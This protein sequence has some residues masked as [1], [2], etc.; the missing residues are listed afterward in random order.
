M[1]CRF[2][3]CDIDQKPILDFPDEIL[4]HIF[5]FCHILERIRFRLVCR[6]WCRLSLYGIHQLFLGQNSNGILEIDFKNRIYFP[7]QQHARIL[8][9]ATF[10]LKEIGS[11]LH[12]LYTNPICLVVRPTTYSSL[13]LPIYDYFCKFVQI[14]IDYCPNL[15]ELDL[16]SEHPF[17]QMHKVVIQPLTNLA[18]HFGHQLKVFRVTLCL[19]DD[20]Q[21]FLNYLNPQKLRRFSFFLKTPSWL[22]DVCHRFPLLTELEVVS[23]F[24]FRTLPWNSLKKLINIR[25]IRIQTVFFDQFWFTVPNGQDSIDQIV[26]FLEF[27]YPYTRIPNDLKDRSLIKK[28]RILDAETLGYQCQELPYLENVIMTSLTFREL[29]HLKHLKCL[30][31]L[32]F[33]ESEV[34]LESMFPIPSLSRLNFRRIF[35]G[36]DTEKNIRQEKLLTELGRIFPNVED[37]KITTSGSNTSAL[38]EYVKTLPNLRLFI[39]ALDPDELVKVKEEKQLISVCNSR[40]VYLVLTKIRPLRMD[41]D[42]LS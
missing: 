28:M 34:R 25:K 7:I 13:D 16:G 26:K 18:K 37:V 38:I 40:N 36:T 2:C 11:S 23:L 14:L 19:A 17:L 4:L 1:T 12:S 27:Y 6:K 29:Y 33:W 8:K 39:L 9:A 41:Q 3:P 32:W 21:T 31:F 10:L 5:N 20:L 22:E 30:S 15:V 24:W 35:L 42:N